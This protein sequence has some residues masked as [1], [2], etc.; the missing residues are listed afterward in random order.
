M[1]C[2]TAHKRTHVCACMQGSSGGDMWGQKR[3]RRGPPG[4]IEPQ[5]PQVISQAVP[6]YGAAPHGSGDVR[7]DLVQGRRPPGLPLPSV[8][9]ATNPAR[10]GVG[11]A[12]VAGRLR[13]VTSPSRGCI[14]AA[15]CIRE[16]RAQSAWSPV[17]GLQAVL[18]TVSGSAAPHDNGLHLACLCP[19][20]CTVG[21]SSMVFSWADERQCKLR[22]SVL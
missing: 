5:L 18:C 3:L 16:R 13:A 4:M 6:H 1:T 21:S 8:H 11:F 15:V 20:T 10:C 22:L 12:C 7:P 2:G 14:P 19:A 17:G 9:P